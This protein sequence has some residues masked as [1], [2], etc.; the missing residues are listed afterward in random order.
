ML[1][2]QMP[3]IVSP[4]RPTCQRNITAFKPRCVFFQIGSFISDPGR[5]C[6]FGYP[7]T[8]SGLYGYLQVGEA[9]KDEIQIEWRR[10]IQRDESPSRSPD[11]SCCR[12][13]EEASKS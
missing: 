5:S 7:L 8:R 3:I 12:S 4:F 1:G 11:V 13:Q 9:G 2:L 10:W 6:A